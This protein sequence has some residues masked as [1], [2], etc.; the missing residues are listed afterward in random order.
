MPWILNFSQNALKLFACRFSSDFKYD[1]TFIGEGRDT[2]SCEVTVSAGITE[3]STMY[4]EVEDINSEYGVDC[5][6]I[7]LKTDD[8]F[9]PLDK[10]GF[11]LEKYPD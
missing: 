6:H 1:R 7:Y 10:D 2:N 9:V 3:E 4:I 5:R 8:G 11:K